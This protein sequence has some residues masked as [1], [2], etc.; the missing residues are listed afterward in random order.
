MPLVRNIGVASEPTTFQTRQRGSNALQALLVTPLQDARKACLALPPPQA[1]VFDQPT[2][3]SCEALDVPGC[4]RVAVHAVP[5]EIGH[6]ADFAGNHDG[7]A[8]AHGLVHG[9]PPGFVFRR[10]HEYV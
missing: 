5:N 4:R 9:K 6:T 1:L 2:E 10:Q 7:K 8:G 3:C